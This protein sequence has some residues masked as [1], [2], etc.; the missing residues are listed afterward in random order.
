MQVTFANATP[1]DAAALAEIS[2]R[3]FDDDSR[4]FLGQEPGGPP[5]YDSAPWQADMMRRGKY[6]KIL[7][8]GRLAGGLIVFRMGGD[9]YEL[10]RIF[11]DPAFQNRGL[12]GQA[13]R[14]IETAFPARRW[15]LDT[16]T[17]ATRNHHF[18][19]KLGYV[20]V[21]EEGDGPARLV[22]YEKRLPIGE[23]QP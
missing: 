3:T 14:W 15:T 6:V 7:A 18:Y 21:R 1:A 13:M 2:R 16:P 9:H 17:W 22:F 8:D 10:G 23:T 11:I 20:R 19:E 4:R 5:G 12:G